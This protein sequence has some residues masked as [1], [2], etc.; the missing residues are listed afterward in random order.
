M[1]LFR[2]FRFGLLA[3]IP[4]P[5][6]GMAILSGID[7]QRFEL[8]NQM[9]NNLAKKKITFDVIVGFSG[10]T[11]CFNMVYCTINSVKYNSKVGRSDRET[12]FFLG[13]MA[14]CF[15]INKKKQK[16]R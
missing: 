16:N 15:E 4:F 9:Q 11:F 10:L 1:I 2:L 6:R 3:I 14:D 8:A 13:K 5:V 12:C 7:F